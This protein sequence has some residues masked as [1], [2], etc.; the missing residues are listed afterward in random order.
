[1]KHDIDLPFSAPRDWLTFRVCF[2]RID[3]FALYHRIHTSFRDLI[4][5]FNE[6]DK[7]IHL[8]LDRIHSIFLSPRTLR[9]NRYEQFHFRSRFHSSWQNGVLQQPLKKKINQ[10]YLIEFI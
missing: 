7:D 1:M 6:M 3:D 2:E 8:V 5:S 10:Q 4:F 9:I